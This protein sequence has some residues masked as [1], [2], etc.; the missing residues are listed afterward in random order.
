MS[1]DESLP[2]DNL[3]DKA[4]SSA[5]KAVDATKTAAT[6][7]LD[8]VADKVESVRSTLSP[9]LNTATAPLDAVVNYTREKPLSAL[10][11]AAATGA[12]L[13]AIVRPSRRIR[14]RPDRR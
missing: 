9:A 3:V 10:L 7:A 13:F 2:K 11:A 4:A 5:T 12:L 6:A 8:S 1:T 14:R